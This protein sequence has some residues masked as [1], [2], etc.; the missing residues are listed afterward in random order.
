MISWLKLMKIRLMRPWNRFSRRRRLKNRTV[1]II[2]NNCWGG[3]MMKECGLPFNTPFVG[4]FMFDEDYV[5]MLEDPGVLNSPLRFISREES[6]HVI[7][8]PKIYPIGVIGDGL[9][10]HF[11]HYGSEAE[12]RS[13][14]ER[15]VG[16]IDFDNLIVKFGDEDGPRPD[17]LER[18]DR[19]PYKHKVA[20]TGTDYP[21]IQSAVMVPYYTDE[22]HVGRDLYKVSNE[23]WDFVDHANRIADEKS[24]R[25]ETE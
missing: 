14:W 20:F 21:R 6:C 3:F 13:K 24:N 25:T 22:R 23:V 4:L 16:R 7:S 15:R 2:S 17:L 10:I 8:D 11:L 19:L 1:S 9:E 5:R 18:F 12:A